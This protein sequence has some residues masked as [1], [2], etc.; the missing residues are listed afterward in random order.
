MDV[1]NRGIA[2]D[3]KDRSTK[4]PHLLA[5]LCNEE[6]CCRRR[7][8]TGR[9]GSDLG[10]LFLD[11]VQGCAIGR[12][13][14]ATVEPGLLIILVSRTQSLGAIIEGITKWFVDALKGVASSHENLQSDEFQDEYWSES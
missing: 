11:S 10:T 8:Y 3:V 5:M 13:S 9:G 2:D 4:K 6:G 7:S 14:K 1:K 12:L